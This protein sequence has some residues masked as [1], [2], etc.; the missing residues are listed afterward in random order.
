MTKAEAITEFL[1]CH[2]FIDTGHRLLGITGLVA[3]G[4]V[5]RLPTV[6]VVEAYLG[7]RF[8]YGSLMYHI[9]EYNVKR[10]GWLVIGRAEA[11]A[12]LVARLGE[13]R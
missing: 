8:G 1:K 13:A 10:Y 9:A 11:E 12:I 5:Y 2:W 3:E 7:Y 4:S 6:F